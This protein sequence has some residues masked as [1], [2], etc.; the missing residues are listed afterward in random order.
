[1]KKL[2]FTT[3]ILINILYANDYDKA[4]D[5][6]K[7]NKFKEAAQYFITSANNG[8]SEAAYIMGYFYTGGIGVKQDL[9][10]SVKWYEKAAKQGHI[11]AQVNLGWD[12]I[13]GLG[14]KVDYKKAAYWIKKAKQ[15]GSQKAQTLWNEFNLTKYDTME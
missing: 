13:G 5:L 12:Y 1:M 8:N 9:K 2:F 14:V 11:N 7:Q 3:I 15:Q 6:Y 10:K 4:I